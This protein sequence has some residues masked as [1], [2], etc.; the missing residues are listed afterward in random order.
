MNARFPAPTHD[1]QARDAVHLA[2]DHHDRGQTARAHAAEGRQREQTVSRRL[3]VRLD[4]QNPLQLLKDLLRPLHVAGR[5]QAD[6]NHIL[7]LRLRREVV[8]EADHAGDVRLRQKQL[9]RNVKLNLA[10]QVPEDML[11]T[12]QHLNQMAAAAGVLGV[13]AKACNEGIQFGELRLGTLRQ[14]VATH[15]FILSFVDLEPQPSLT[16]ALHTQKE[17]CKTSDRAQ[18][19]LPPL[20]THMESPRQ[21][22]RH[23]D[24]RTAESPL[25]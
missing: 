20:H 11:G 23:A 24:G 19:P 16:T 10:G 22:Q 18:K 4:A 5:A 21:G 8:V 2:V 14:L 25:T 6:V 12:M 15:V 17:K 1:K 9:L 13:D 3:R 7:A